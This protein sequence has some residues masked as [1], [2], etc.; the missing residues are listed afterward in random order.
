MFTK[1]YHIQLNLPNSFIWKGFINVEADKTEDFP[2]IPEGEFSIQ[3]DD[4]GWH[5]QFT[6]TNAGSCKVT[7]N[8]V[9]S[10]WYALIPAAYPAS[11]SELTITEAVALMEKYDNKIGDASVRV[12]LTRGRLE[13]CIRYNDYTKSPLTELWDDAGPIRFA[14]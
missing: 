5:G 11:H 6:L 9:I 13:K 4:R 8:S 1:K 7:C 14:R 3:R 12:P 2:E 10:T